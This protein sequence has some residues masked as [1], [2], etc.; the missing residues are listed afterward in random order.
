MAARTRV[1]RIPVRGTRYHILLS[2][3]HYVYTYIYAHVSARV[4]VVI[5]Q[6][7]ATH[8]QGGA[9]DAT[10]YLFPCHVV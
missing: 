6:D 9:N 3:L 7:G 10:R 4:L 5:G 8:V 1:Y 2:I